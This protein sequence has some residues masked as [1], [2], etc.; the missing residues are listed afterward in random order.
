VNDYFIPYYVAKR[1]FWSVRP[2][3][4]LLPVTNLCN[5]CQ[6]WDVPAETIMWAKVMDWVFCLVTYR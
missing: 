1:F 3:F 5:S 6:R 4:Q 2:M